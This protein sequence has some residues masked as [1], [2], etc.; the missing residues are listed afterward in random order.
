MKPGL[1]FG[2]ALCG[3]VAACDDPQEREAAHMEHGRAFFAA[4]NL[5]KARVELRNTLEMNPYNAEA[6]YVLAQ[7][8]EE[9]GNMRAAF[10][11]YLQAADPAKGHLAAQL[12][13]AKTLIAAGQLAEA[14]GRVNTILGLAPR[15]PDALALLAAI[16]L[17]RGE[18]DRAAMKADSVLAT[19]PDHL[20]ALTIRAEIH[21]EQGALAST[22]AL[23]ERGLARKA[24]HVPLLLQQARLHTLQQNTEAAI[25]TYRQ[26]IALAPEEVAYWGGFATLLIGFGQT[27]EAERV[28][29]EG[30]A[31]RPAKKTLKMLL[32]DFL[33]THRD[34][35]Q[36][37]AETRRWLEAAQESSFYDSMLATLYMR[38]GDH[39]AAQATLKAAVAR[40]GRGTGGPCRPKPLSPRC[41]P[42]VANR[43]GRTR[44]WPRFCA[45]IPSNRKPCWC[46]RALPCAPARTARP[47]LI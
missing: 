16:D 26:V 10:V 2:L 32:V 6:S 22:G 3:V 45:R 19:T 1:V 4:G 13:I 8:E 29:R 21:Y 7:V 43:H 36:A 41:W 24:D 44:W 46:G 15:N 33:A 20:D 47:S 5:P 17:Q 40:V 35:G 9:A 34:P 28:L 42:I 25:A 38:M 18:L 27:D 14:T 39:E 12:K 37:I 30:M 11:S 23:V 31:A